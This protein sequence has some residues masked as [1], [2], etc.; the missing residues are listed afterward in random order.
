MLAAANSIG[1][2]L[3]AEVQVL[4]RVLTVLS[5]PQPFFPSADW[6]RLAEDDRYI[7]VVA[8][9]GNWYDVPHKAKEVAAAARRLPGA[10]ILLTGGRK[11]RLTPASAVELGGEPMLLQR[12]LQEQYAVS[13]SRMVIWTGS[14]VTTHNLRTILHYT[15][16]LMEFRRRP[17]QLLL[18]REVRSAPS[19]PAARLRRPP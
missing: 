3:A 2:L 11:E 4:D 17:A 15:K 10:D 6:P 7:S 8:V 5:S 18:A 9:C 1:Q 13:P 12:E 19:R 16:Q 14:R